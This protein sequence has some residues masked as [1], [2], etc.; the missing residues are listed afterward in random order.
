MLEML[1]TMN[2]NY[3]EENIVEDAFCF[4]CEKGFG[5][6]DG[7]VYIIDEPYCCIECLVEHIVKNIERELNFNNIARENITL[8]YLNKSFAKEAFNHLNRHYGIDSNKKEVIINKAKELN[9]EYLLSLL[10]RY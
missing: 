2:K 1:F 5:V 7:G 9:A 3:V 8:D 4:N 10:E 6:N